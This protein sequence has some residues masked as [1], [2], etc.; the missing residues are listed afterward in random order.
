MVNQKTFFAIKP[1]YSEDPVI[2]SA[3]MKM[4]KDTNCNIYSQIKTQYTFEQATEHYKEIPEKFRKA[5]ATYLSSGPIIGFILED[6]RPEDQR[7]LDFITYFRGVLG[8]TKCQNPGTIRNTIT[9]D[10]RFVDN[11]KR[12]RA[13]H[14]NS[15]IGIDE[16]TT[17][18]AHASDSYESFIRETKI[19]G[20]YNSSLYCL[21]VLYS[22]NTKALIECE[23]K[24]FEKKYL[25]YIEI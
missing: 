18:V 10:P 17:N 20:T 6:G 11:T 24:E 7:D 15:E 23:S 22:D 1:G 13:K 16:I 8:D 2:Y 14:M 12:I 21:I 25:Q 9:T 3:I 19:L 4:L 5:A